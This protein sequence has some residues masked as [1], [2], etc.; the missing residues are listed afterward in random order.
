MSA[1]V[2]RDGAETVRRH[3]Q[4]LRVPHVGVEGPAVAEDHGATH[5]PVLV[6]DAH[7]V[8]RGGVTHCG[9]LACSVDDLSMHTPPG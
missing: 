2:V 9:L 5:P 7:A 8:L 6:E 4:Q 3:E 1:P